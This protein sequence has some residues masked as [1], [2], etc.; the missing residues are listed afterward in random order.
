MSELLSE[1]TSGGH[2]RTGDLYK[3]FAAKK[4]LRLKGLCGSANAMAL[5]SIIPKIPSWHLII[6]PDGESAAYFYNDLEKASGKKDLL[7]YPSAWKRS[8]TRM[9]IDEGNLIL[10]TGVLEKLTKEKE[11]PGI[12]ICEAEAISEKII[13]D[14]ALG[15]HTFPINKGENLSI[16]FLR[17]LLLEYGFHQTEFVYEPGQFAVRGSI[18]DVFSYS[19]PTPYR[20]DFFGSSVESIRN[21]DPE[22]QLSDQIFE[23]VHLI[24][25]IQRFDHASGSSCL[26]D[27][28]PDSTFIWSIDPALT[29]DQWKKLPGIA[30]TEITEE[31]ESIPL[32]PEATYWS[33]E[34]IETR[35]H[36]FTRVE[37]GMETTTE[38]LP[39]VLFNTQPQPAFN[40]RFDRLSQDLGIFREKGYTCYILSENPKQFERLKA[41]FEN[42]PEKATF[43]PIQGTLH[44]GFID[45]DHQRVFYTDHQI[46]ERYH[47]FQVKQKFSKSESLT[48]QDF[49][50]LHPGDFVVHIDHGVGIFGGLEKINN[51]G[52]YQESI[53]LVYRDNDILY[54]SLHNLHKI[55]KYRG[56]DGE[57]PKIYKLGS[58]AWQNLKSNTK[59]KIKDIARDLILLYAKRKA[60][61]GF[62]FSPDSMLQ[63]ELE[64]SFLYEDTP[65]QM[66]ATLAVK[67]GMEANHPMDHLVC[68]DVGFGKTE[69]AIRAAFK[70]VLDNKQVAVLVPTTL[71]AFQH[72]N[73]FKDRLK[74][75]PVTVDFICRL[76]TAKEQKEIIK[77]LEEGKIDILIGTH[78]IVNKEIKFKDLG[79]LIIDEEQKF[80]V[81]VKEKLKSIR[82]NVD[83]LTLTATPIPRTLQF[84][85][86]GARELSIINTPPPNR[87]PIKTEVTV[88]DRELVREAIQHEVGRGGQ[89]F[90]VHHRISDLPSIKNMLDELCPGVRTVIAHGQMDGDYLEKVMLDFLDGDFDILLST[91]I[92]ESGL[93]VPNANTIFISSA[94]HFGLSD[95]HQLRGRVGRSNKKAYC[96]LLVPDVRELKPDARRR[97]R[98][99]EQFSELGSGF[100]IAMQDLDI[101]GAGNLIGAEQSGFIADIGFETY[102]R[103]L[104]EALEELREDEFRELLSENKADSSG[105]PE[106]VL[107]AGQTPEVSG[108]AV[109][110]PPVENYVSEC[111]IDTDLEVL[112][113]ETYVGNITERL[114]LYQELDNIN[115]KKALLK[116]IASL[117]DRFGPLPPQTAELIEVV[118]LRLLSFRLGIEKISLRGGRLTAWFLSNPQSSFYHSERFTYILDFIVKHPKIFSLKE[119]KEKLSLTATQ[120]VKV[121]QAVRILSQLDPAQEVNPQ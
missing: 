27:L 72:Y 85:L 55:S 36:R 74:E 67:S 21:F 107:S 49:Q 77:R 102:Q 41:I 111:Q 110:F 96:Y 71:L 114:R 76:R 47:N 18:I 64:A 24:P 9:Q 42:L 62:S 78:R 5:A 70:A 23:K 88:F 84:S 45:H 17:E 10:R 81:A 48:L 69:V 92:V 104:N 50:G 66:K 12:V 118:R 93:D 119:T 32:N 20:I 40:K 87:H 98:A 73:T 59:K 117:E 31:E 29:I 100:N 68:G 8:R 2:P 75:F 25:N 106:K 63:Q 19:A 115:D 52:K 57:P 34:E 80:G 33:G 58:S 90:Y 120:I 86:L 89:I 28:L 4:S 60:V 53:R 3:A 26:L 113:P 61:E 38:E 116:Y 82:V 97:I 65:D 46:F 39:E 14:K 16:P 91:T 1:I 121:S 101:R 103:I 15:D 108:K 79:I 11:K 13:S 83:T 56:K 44:E 51:N 109:S 95:L 7:F 54:V 37:M 112:L 6:L 94:D 99:I 35:Y 43:I 30:L 22:S 105:Q